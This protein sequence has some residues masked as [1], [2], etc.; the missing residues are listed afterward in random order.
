[1]SSSQKSSNNQL[2]N[3]SIKKRSPPKNQDP[4]KKKKISE[5]TMGDIL[6]NN[7]RFL[8]QSY[9]SIY[10][11]LSL[12][13]LNQLCDKSKSALHAH[14][15]I[16]LEGNIIQIARE[17]PSKGK[18][19]RKFYRLNPNKLSDT[20][21]VKIKNHKDQ[22]RNPLIEH[23]LTE[24]ELLSQ[25]ELDKTFAL[26]NISFL[27]K[28]IQY[29]DDLEQMVHSGNATKVMEIYHEFK[30]WETFESVAFYSTTTAKA[31]KIKAKA[32]F[33]EFESLNEQDIAQSGLLS[34][35]IYASINLIPI[36]RVLENIKN[37]KKKI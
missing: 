21:N 32:L 1:M 11:E 4:K 13:Q 18:Y 26:S 33:N 5:F 17:E 19:T 16:L 12:V 37:K 22:E 9:L 2:K 6:K 23:G 36:G 30:R 25:L 24:E 31:F 15:N 14:L 10:P 3:R 29:L 8:I 7:I 27:E 35:P 20:R 28:W 34:R